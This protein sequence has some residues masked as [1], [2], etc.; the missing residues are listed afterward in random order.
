MALPDSTSQATAVG[1]GAKN[2]PFNFTGTNQDAIVN[3][4]GTYDPSILTITDELPIE[5]LS[6]ADVGNRTGY[7][8]MLHRLAI[9]VFE[10]LGG[11]GKVYI[12]PQSE[13][14]GAAASTGDIL[15]AGTTTTAAGTIH[16]RVGGKKYSVAIPSGTTIEDMSGL[17]VA[18]YNADADA[19]MVAAVTAV[20]FETAFTA[21]S[22][23]PWGDE[24]T[25]SVNAGIDEELP[26][27]ITSATVT[28]MSG[29]TG[30]PDID[31]ALDGTGT[32]DDANE[33]DATHMVHGYGLDTDT[34]DKISAYVGEG[35]TFDGLYS[36][37]IGRPFVCLNG[38]NTAGT[39]GY[40]ALRVI[41]DARLE[42]RANGYEA[43]P[44]SSWHPSEIASLA[45]GKIAA[46]MQSN[47]AQHYAGISLGGVDPGD[48]ADRWT[49]DYSV[50][51]LAVKGGISPTRVVAG[52]VKLQNV[53]TSYRP[54][55]IAVASNGYK[56]FRSFAIT[57]NILKTLR[58]LFEGE[59]WQGVSIVADVSE[60]SDFE[61]AQKVRDIASVRTALNNITDFFVS[62][63]WL[64]DGDF[65]KQEST[66]AIRALSN[67]FDINY[68]YKISGEAQIYN[69]QASFDTNIAA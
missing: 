62:K 26:A 49:K 2:V 53:I 16:L 13:A 47:P 30:I 4:I 56:S 29:G 43:A 35:N 51:D 48:V 46:T 44:D 60:V 9:Q 32:D 17:V 39:A 52:T 50:R 63:S 28:A 22:K 11:S 21:K 23:G 8:F 14:G 1:I 6:A 45:I 24:I 64:Y 37:L 40:T 36:K 34:I 3:I 25:I 19:S 54:A 57:R 61:A 55:S 69:V 67:G 42:D 66:V 65:A 41:T 27:G 15:Y 31:D 12:T 58:E 68:K 59:D 38:D 33:I 20:T 5:V 18:Q 10:G 7:G